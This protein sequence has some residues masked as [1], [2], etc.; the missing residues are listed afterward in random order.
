MA[1][2]SASVRIAKPPQ[3]VFDTICDYPS[4]PQWLK[5]IKE[6]KFVTPGPLRPGSKVKVVRGRI[7]IEFTAKEVVP[8]RQ[9]TM[10][11]SQGKVTGVT[12]F[13]LKPDGGGTTVEHTLDLDLKGLLKLFGFVIG[14]GLKKDLQALKT[15]VE[16]AAN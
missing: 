6:A 15:R 2:W 3:N 10:A 7:T 8:P 14:R 12:T 9:L 4:T 16:G 13:T 11:I 5:G 1:H